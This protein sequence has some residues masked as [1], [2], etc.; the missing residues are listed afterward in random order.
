[1]CAQLW[2]PQDISVDLAHHS[3]YTGSIG[4]AGLG[5]GCS[6]G[7]RKASNHKTRPK[8]GTLRLL[9]SVTS[10]SA[11]KPT[12]HSPHEPD[13]AEDT[14]IAT[15]PRMRKLRVSGRRNGLAQAISKD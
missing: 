15:R 5:A 7:D 13:P 10:D 11:G 4:A 12:L 3:G 2:E 1:M 8:A 9:T 6:R 14:A